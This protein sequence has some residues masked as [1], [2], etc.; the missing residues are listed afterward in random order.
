MF[1]G[2]YTI[3]PPEPI[4]HE[5]MALDV[6]DAVLIKSIERNNPTKEAIP[7]SN[8]NIE[9]VPYTFDAM[10]IKNLSEKNM[11]EFG[12]SGMTD[13]SGFGV[14]PRTRPQFGEAE[15][16]TDAFWAKTRHRNDLMRKVDSRYRDGDWFE[17]C[18]PD[19]HD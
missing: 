19:D 8:N 2:D 5:Y 18:K 14:P 17:S 1:R 13:F 11:A 3:Y 12:T 4:K 7:M 16:T 15:H 10:N 6:N 9:P